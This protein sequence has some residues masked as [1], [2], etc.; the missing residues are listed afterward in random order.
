MR[1]VHSIRTQAYRRRSL[2]PWQKHFPPILGTSILQE[3]VT[4]ERGFENIILAHICEAYCTKILVHLQ[5]LRID[6]AA[7]II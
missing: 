4:A 2:F 7:Q 6:K 3:D 5:C 1:I